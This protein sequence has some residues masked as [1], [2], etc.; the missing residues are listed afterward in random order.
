[1]LSSFA[2]LSPATLIRSVETSFALDLDATIETLPSYVN[3]VYGLRTVDGVPLVAK[4]YR[5]G[6]WSREA[7]LEE[8]T[9]L[10]DCAAA[11]LPVVLPLPDSKG[12]TLPTAYDDEPEPEA[13]TELDRRTENQYLVAGYEEGDDDDRRERGSL[14]FLLNKHLRQ[15]YNF[16]LFPRRSGRNFDAERP[17]DWRRLGSLCARMH[18]VGQ[19][20]QAKHRVVCSPEAWGASSLQELWDAAV[21]RGESETEFFD[22]G[23]DLL[24][25][26]APVFQGVPLQRIHG[27]L[28]RGNILDRGSEGLLLFDFDDMMTGPVAQD[29]W[30]LLPDQIE[31]CASEVRN[32]V[33]GYSEFGDPGPGWTTLV[34]PLRF[35]RMVHFLAWCS[36]QR[37][38]ERFRN[39][40]PDWGSR[41]FWV[42][43]IE[44]LRQQSDVLRSQG[45]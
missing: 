40:F 12:E 16:A 4:F 33:D 10:A 43:E 45:I 26:I 37:N 34:E 20:R 7:I 29:L 1:M 36:R 13:Q 15:T 25:R 3:R 6:R 11:E 39:T 2:G 32:L 5:P 30:L 44:D 41:A 38:D 28:H 35:L 22:L 24:S 14:D 27:D 19:K 23:E 42:K 31:R 18:L 21:V 8:H 17:E 9:F